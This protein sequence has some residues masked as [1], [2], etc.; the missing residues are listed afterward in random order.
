MRLAVLKRTMSTTSKY[1]I[2]SLPLPPATHI[3]THNLTPDE[4]T[5]SV[6]AF[7]RVLADKPSLQRRAR[8]LAA[9]AHYSH[10]TPFPVPFPFEI[11]APEPPAVVEDKA[12]YVENWLANR[13][14]T[15]IRGEAAPSGL[16]L[17]YAESRE[18]PRELIGL[19]E[20]G[21][22]DC[23]P[24]LDVGDALPCLG[25]P[26]LSQE[27][28]EE[29]LPKQSHTETEARQQL[30]DVLSGHAVL[31]SSDNA[32]VHY[33]PWSLRYS[34][35]QFGSWAGQLGDG[36]AISLCTLHISLFHAISR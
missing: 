4:H 24:H 7:K 3:L 34:G 6:P 25:T 35:H 29:E 17:H 12:A 14:A 31:M 23:L 33:A 21:W 36:R 27:F 19:A 30:V 28:E 20:A 16:G 5:P 8:L 22:K 11:I 1:P 13:E 18:Q 2:S 9:P 10:V 32:V 26:T 15:H